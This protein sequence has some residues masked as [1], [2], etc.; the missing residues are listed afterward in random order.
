MRQTAFQI[1]PLPALLLG[2]PS[3]RVFLFLHGQGGSKE[4]AIPFA[5]LAVP[6]GWQVLGVDLVR[7][8]PWD[9]LEDLRQVD[10]YVSQHWSEWSIRANSLGAW[11]S[12]LAFSGR[13]VKHSLFVS[14][15]L[16]MER[17][18][19]DMMKWAGVTEERLEQEKEIPTSFGQ[20]LSWA[21]LSYV[22]QH[23]VVDWTVPTEI[24]YAGQDSMV[25]RETVDAFVQTH[26]C[27]LTVLDQGE[28]WFHTPE[29]LQFL[30][31]WEEKCFDFM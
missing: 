9:A 6:K 23:P 21:Y 29:Q 26:T 13:P 5:G 4:E 22:R 27:G 7:Q 10:A 20:T 14:P 24:L 17:L 25:A 3:R 2:E 15:V 19:L 1:G 28:H 16:D 18:I 30:K 31:T 8:L 11:F 12:L